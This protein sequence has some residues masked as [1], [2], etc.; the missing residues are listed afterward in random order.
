MTLKD[1]EREAAALGAADL[2]VT[3]NGAPPTVSI[4]HGADGDT[5]E[6]E[7]VGK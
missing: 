3:V 1:I 6:L 7:E 4:L 5:L 2:H